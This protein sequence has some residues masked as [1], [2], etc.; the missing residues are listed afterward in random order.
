MTNSTQANLQAITE[1]SLSNNALSYHKQA[2]IDLNNSGI[3][4]SCYAFVLHGTRAA[5]RGALTVD[6]G[7]YKS[8][9]KA[10]EALDALSVA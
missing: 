4:A 3:L 7:V 9:D 5:A 1:E 2:H 6:A 10:I 8:C